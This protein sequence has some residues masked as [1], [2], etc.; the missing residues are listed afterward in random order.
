[1]R[2]RLLPYGPGGWLVELDEHDV[3]GYA[4]AVRA[5]AHPGVAEVVPAART[6]LVRVAEP[7]RSARSGAWLAGL[8][9][10]RSTATAG[11]RRSRSR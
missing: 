2:P 1:M 10:S 11:T 5:I 8:R 9:R 7:A 4:A 3:I 6:V